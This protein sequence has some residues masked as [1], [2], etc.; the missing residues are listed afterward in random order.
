MLG[1]LGSFKR[2]KRRRRG[3]RVE[4]VRIRGPFRLRERATGRGKNRRF[5]SRTI[6]F[7]TAQTVTNR[8]FIIPQGVTSIIAT[9]CSPGSPG[10]YSRE[11]SSGGQGGAGGSMRRA[12]ISV[13]PGQALIINFSESTAQQVDPAPACTVDYINSSN[14]ITFTSTSGSSVVSTATTITGSWT[15]IEAATG[16]SG[17]NTFPSNPGR[18]GGASATLSTNFAGT[19]GL[20][21]AGG[22]G[23]LLTANNGGQPGGVPGGGGGGVFLNSFLFGRGGPGFVRIEVG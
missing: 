18:A 12:S 8:T 13:T 21:G 23:V 19:Q 10:G 2:I 4:R 1:T 11:P 22:T 14:R 5:A 17:D 7:Q 16:S 15:N 20:G 3:R 9:V 6:L